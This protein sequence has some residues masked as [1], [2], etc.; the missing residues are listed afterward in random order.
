M[1][2]SYGLGFVKRRAS[3]YIN[4]QATRFDLYCDRGQARPSIATVHKTTTSKTGCHW[5][6][7][8]KA[9]KENNRQWTF[10]IANQYHNH[11]T[12]GENPAELTTHAV[13]RGLSDAMMKDVE[14]L[15]LNPAQRPRDIVLFLQKRYPHTVFT[16]KDVPITGNCCNGT[17]STDITQLKP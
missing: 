4:G 12:S 2:K 11:D 9:L 6:G 14:A 17:I 13:H 8:A 5:R 10:E 15:S 3:N 7:V 1:G 16:T